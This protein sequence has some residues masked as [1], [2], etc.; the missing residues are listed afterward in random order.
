MVKLLHKFF[1]KPFGKTK[2]IQSMIFDLFEDS[3]KNIFFKE[4]LNRLLESIN[5][6]TIITENDKILF[7]NPR[8]SIYTGYTREE[9]LKMT[10]LDFVH[11]DFLALAK[12]NKANQSE[13]PYEIWVKRKDGSQFPVLLLPKILNFE[14][15]CFRIITIRD[16]TQDKQHFQKELLLTKTLGQ[17]HESIIIT[18]TEATI[19]YVNERFCK[20]SG[21]TKEEVLGQNPKILQSGI[22]SKKFYQSMWKTLVSGKEW[23]G[24]FQN[25]KKDGTIY[26]EKATITPIQNENGKIQSYLGIKEDITIQK[27]IEENFRDTEIKYKELV[28][29]APL[30]IITID[31]KGNVVMINQMMVDFLGSPSKKETMKINVLNFPLLQKAG[32]SAQFRECLDSGKKIKFESNYTSKWSK[33][34]FYRLYLSPLKNSKEEVTGVL[35][36]A[37]DISKEKAYEEGI[38]EAKTKAVESDRLKDVFLANMS[39]ELRTP[40]NAIIGFSEFLKD[41]NNLTQEQN[42]YV[43]YIDTSANHLLKLIGDLV[44]VS[45]ME[46]KQLTFNLENFKVGDLM[47]SIIPIAKNQLSYL[48]K[49]NIELIINPHEEIKEIVLNVDKARFTQVITNLIDNAIKYTE[50]GEI[51][52]NCSVQDKELVIAVKDTGIG[53]PKDKHQ[54]I[55]ERFRQVEEELSRKYE[56]NGLGLTLVKELVTIM[57]GRVW[58]DSTP[59]KGSTFF[60]AFPIVKSEKS[61]GKNENISQ[62]TNQQF[63]NEKFTVLLVEDNSQNKIL[64]RHILQ[65]YNFNVLE[66][67]NGKEAVKIFNNTPYINVILMDLQMPVMDGIEATKIIRKSNSTIPIIAQTALAFPEDKSKALDAGCNDILLKPFKKDQLL[68]KIID[69]LKVF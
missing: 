66:A 64:I 46:S 5:E 54:L 24:E 7:V 2:N 48:Q 58:L 41:A 62:T 20:L 61:P 36:I 28:D 32:V 63:K 9:I 53:I 11:P 55:F 3:K 44:D 37:E 45:R 47:T 68:L 52:L 57:K 13:T 40:L 18:D 51:R 43:E 60:V 65:E 14:G 56:G 10:P 42:K 16:L 69:N 21:Y 59:G 1:V 49:D 67:N 33:K 6:A 4:I 8:F 15:R 25:K 12:K 29:N 50:E 26:W 22:H 35:A 19:I 27:Q 34:M 31:T 30:A 23:K 39:H 17:S 38:L